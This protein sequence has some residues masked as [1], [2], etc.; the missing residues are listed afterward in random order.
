MMIHA[1]DEGCF[2]RDLRLTVVGVD[3]DLPIFRIPKEQ[4]LIVPLS[5]SRRLV[6]K[7]ELKTCMGLKHPC[8][9]LDYNPTLFDPL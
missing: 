2:W 4:A 7:E 9:V 5:D 1:M 8:W 6:P 3:F